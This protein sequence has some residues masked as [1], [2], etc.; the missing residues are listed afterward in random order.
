MSLLQKAFK[1]EI[2]PTKEQADKI[3]QSIGICRYLY[4]AYI[5]K[6]KKLYQL[7]Q[8]GILD[9]RVK[10]NINKTVKV[11]QLEKRLKR[12]QRALSRKYKN[13]KKRGEKNCYLL[14]KYR[15][16]QAEST[17]TSSTDRKY[18]Y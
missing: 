11:K 10:K 12:Q 17:E 5:A 6:N 16:K 14:C 3:R 2:K 4:N 13:R 7:Y 1:T 8:R 9:G 15:E 18:S